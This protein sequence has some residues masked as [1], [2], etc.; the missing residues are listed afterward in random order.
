MG[1]FGTSVEMETGSSD[2]CILESCVESTQ[3]YLLCIY[4]IYIYILMCV[5]FTLE[6]NLRNG[7]GF[8]HIDHRCS[9]ALVK[10]S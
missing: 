8:M 2:V 4:K 3:G 5:C 7:C 10:P 9:K 6:S 1:F